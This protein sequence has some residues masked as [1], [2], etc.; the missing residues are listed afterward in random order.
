MHSY[1]PLGG[2]GVG[3]QEKNSCKNSKIKDLI[4]ISILITDYLLYFTFY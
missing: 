2:W 1:T 3:G 4:N